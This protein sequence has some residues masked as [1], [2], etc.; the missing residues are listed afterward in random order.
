ME[1]RSERYARCLTHI[2]AKHCTIKDFRKNKGKLFDRTSSRIVKQ[3]SQ[4][5]KSD[6]CWIDGFQAKLLFYLAVL[7]N[8]ALYCYEANSHD[9]GLFYTADFSS[10]SERQEGY[11]YTALEAVLLAWIAFEL[12]LRFRAHSLEFFSD[13]WNIFDLLLLL[14]GSIDSFILNWIPSAAVQESHSCILM[15]L[16]PLQ[17]IRIGRHVSEL[18][19]LIFG[20][21]SAAQAVLWSMSLMLLLIYL[22]AV[23]CVRYLPSSFPDEAVVVQAFGTVGNAMLTLFAMATLESFSATVRIFFE[24]GPEGALVAAWLVVFIIVSNFALLNLIMAVMVNSIIDTLPKRSA[25]K[26]AKENAEAV[27][28]LEDL[29]CKIDE[30]DDGVISIQ[31]LESSIAHREN[32]RN[33][34]CYFLQTASFDVKE[35]FHLLNFSGNGLVSVEEFISGLLTIAPGSG[36][37]KEVLG[38]QHDMH[39]MWNMLAAG[40]ERVMREMA[41]CLEEQRRRSDEGQR[42][43]AELESL[44]LELR[45]RHSAPELRTS[46]PKATASREVPGSELPVLL[47]SSSLRS[48]RSQSEGLLDTLEDLKGS[49]PE[50]SRG[51]R[52]EGQR[53]GQRAER[54]EQVYEWLHQQELARMEAA[55]LAYLRR[56]FSSVPFHKLLL[57][58]EARGIQLSKTEQETLRHRLSPEGTR[59]TAQLVKANAARRTTGLDAPLTMTI[60]SDSVPL[61]SPI[62]AKV[63]PQPRVLRELHPNRQF[64]GNLHRNASHSPSKS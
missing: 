43:R 29:F 39:Q 20:L 2:K 1:H 31:E 49:S 25:E 42:L 13:T 57:Q 54:A 17:L 56:G 60:R 12:V 50:A 40:Q 14:A 41:S 5:F 21:V 4:L 46:R 16:C 33:E 9:S 26:L 51:L 63:D 8:A 22:N 45:A 44:R 27:K 61:I 48:S 3:V 18:R 36:H 30:N 34:L 32:V 47:R 55:P 10:G 64:T 62:A 28:R 37:Q 11:L 15:L 59:L 52:S 24:Y 58:L 35:L 23:L 6:N 53:L 38:L 7:L 19:L